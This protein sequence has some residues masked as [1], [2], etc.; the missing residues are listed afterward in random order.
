MH[1]SISKISWI[2]F[3]VITFERRRFFFLSSDLPKL[4]MLKIFYVKGHS[5]LDPYSQ[6]CDSVTLFLRVIIPS[7]TLWKNGIIMD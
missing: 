5:R 1:R 7:L 6:I 4:S 3:A 2:N